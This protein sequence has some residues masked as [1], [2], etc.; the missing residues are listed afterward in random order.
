M[1]KLL[2]AESSV[3]FRGRLA[4]DTAH[5]NLR[6]IGRFGPS[7]TLGRYR[8][9]SQCSGDAVD[10]EV[11]WGG[12]KFR[13]SLWFHGL[14]RATERGCE[15]TGSIAVPWSSWIGW[16]L[17]PLIF[18]VVLWWQQS[19]ELALWPILGFSVLGL[20]VV[21]LGSRGPRK[22]LRRALLRAI[23]VDLNEETE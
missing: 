8:M 20:A 3:S 6:D 1:R 13:Q 11:T 4:F 2:T 12:L 21:H 14:L 5:E 22:V 19:L 9:R 16:A 23:N 7:S 10:A 18:L 15:L 17:G